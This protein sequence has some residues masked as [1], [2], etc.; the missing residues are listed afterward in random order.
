MGSSSAIWDEPVSLTIGDRVPGIFG[1]TAD[2]LVY[3]LDIQAGRPALVIALDSLSPEAARGMLQRIAAAAPGMR[4]LGGDIVPLASIG[5]FAKEADLRGQGPIVFV[6]EACGLERAVFDGHPGAIVLD[7]SGRILDLQPATAET[8]LAGLFAAAVARAPRETARLD[9]CP[10]P[11]LVIPNV[12]TPELCRQLIDHFEASPHSQGVMASYVDGEAQARLDLDKKKRRDIELP[13]GSEIH[14]LALGLVAARIAPEVKRAFQR[15]ITFA[16]RILIARYDDDGGYFK[17]HRDNAAPQTAFR[18]FAV[19]L[20][21][22]T[23]DYEGGELLFPEYNDHRYS[24]P[25][26]GAIVFSASL[27]HEAAP[28]TRG[29]R[30]VLLTFLCGAS[31]APAASAA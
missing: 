1:A 11:V 28:V 3:S 18:E 25:A 23:D 26:G 24:P 13:A 10:A 12:A 15:D 17:R 2:G 4:A 8:D 30:Y 5:A 20:N 22:N 19:S 6:A 7:R 31:A 21:L 27:L 14:T 16:D 9:A 29:S